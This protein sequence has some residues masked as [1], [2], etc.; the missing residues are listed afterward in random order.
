[1]TRMAW[2]NGTPLRLYEFACTWV[3]DQWAEQAL[4]YAWTSRSRTLGIA[5]KIKP[6]GARDLRMSNVE[7]EQFFL[8]HFVLQGVRGESLRRSNA[9]QTQPRTTESTRADQKLGSKP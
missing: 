1:M 9:K 4:D 2:E 3:Q 8:D 5:C 7:A 6:G